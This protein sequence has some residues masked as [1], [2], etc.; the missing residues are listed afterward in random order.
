MA[1]TVNLGLDQPM[2]TASKFSKQSEN[3][4]VIKHIS[5]PKRKQK[6]HVQGG[7]ARELG[8][9]EMCLA[10]AMTSLFIASVGN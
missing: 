4:L 7:S 10:I 1:L 9:L 3:G 8:I 5:W 2:R 6:H